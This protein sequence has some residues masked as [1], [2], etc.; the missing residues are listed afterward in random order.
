MAVKEAPAKLRRQV[1][2]LLYSP[3]IALPM[4]STW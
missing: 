1:S 2:W 3:E 4:P